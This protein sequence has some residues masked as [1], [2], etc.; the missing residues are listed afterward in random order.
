MER[1]D[2]LKALRRPEIVFP[3]GW[4]ESDPKRARQG[5]IIRWCLSH[6]P[7][8]R[9]GPLDLLRSELLPAAVQDDYISDTLA[10]L[11]KCGDNSTW[12]ELRSPSVAQPN[13]PHIQTVL[14]SL[15]QATGNDR[16]AQ[17][18]AFDVEAGDS[19]LNNPYDKIVKHKLEQ[20]FH[21]R[22]A[23]DFSPPLLMPSS[24]LYDGKARRPVRLLN[25]HGTPVQ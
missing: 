19:E 22:G 6:D 13:S 17:E 11:G 23:V 9:A 12:R 1:I 5:K 3:H 4:D 18:L 7:V 16:R 21:L 20:I 8:K 14:T 2:I 10:L 15:F 25:R 24:D